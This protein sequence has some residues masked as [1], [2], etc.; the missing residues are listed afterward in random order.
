LFFA[1]QHQSDGSQKLVRFDGSTVEFQPVLQEIGNL[2]LGVSSIA[3][4]NGEVFAPE[5][6]SMFLL[7]AGVFAM[8]LYRRYR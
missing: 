3:A 6:R 4:S 5:P 7:G 1:I 8:A 2:P